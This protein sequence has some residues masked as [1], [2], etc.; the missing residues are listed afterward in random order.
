MEISTLSSSFSHRH[1]KAPSGKLTSSTSTHIRNRQLSMCDFTSKDYLRATGHG[2][3]TYIPVHQSWAS[4]CTLRQIS[5]LFLTVTGTMALRCV[6]RRRRPQLAP[7][8]I[9]CCTRIDAAR[10][11]L[12]VGVLASSN[13]F[14]AQPLVSRN[15]P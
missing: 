5:T 6:I 9:T 14:H 1:H 15:G 3:L 7:P 2:M 12:I 4:P 10:A 11:H 13:S 8:S